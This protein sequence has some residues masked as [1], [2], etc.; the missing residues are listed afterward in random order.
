MKSK[1]AS[2]AEVERNRRKLGTS[3]GEC[4]REL[5]LQLALLNRQVGAHVDLNDVDVS[6]LDLISLYGPLSPGALA[7][8]AG[9]H[10]A[11]MT[12]VLDRLEKGRWVVRERDPT[13]RRAVLVRVVRERSVE[14]VR[15]YSGMGNLLREICGRYS[16]AELEVIY[17]FLR[18]TAEAGSNATDELGVD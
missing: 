4:L 1:I 11:T 5:G 12:G 3:I 7:R 16:Q 9:V 18:R 14:L 10:P 17:D 6:S 13:D 15:L 8:R 2:D